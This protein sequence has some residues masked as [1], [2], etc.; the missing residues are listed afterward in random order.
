MVL[1]RPVENAAPAPGDEE[2]VAAVLRGEDRLEELMR[3]HNQRVFRAV[4]AIL[5]DDHEAEDV[6]QHAWVRAWE[7]LDQ[8]EHRARF[9]TWL[10]KIAVYEALARARKGRRSV[11]LPDE[12]P[13]VEASLPLHR[14]AD[15]EEVLSRRRAVEL[16]EAAVDE[17]PERLRS[18][19]VL[20][21]VEG[22]SA[23]ETAAA[24]D[25]SVTAVKVRLHRARRAL[26][27]RLAEYADLRPDELFGFGRERCDRLVARVG[28]DVHAPLT[29]RA[30]VVGGAPPA[31]EA[32]GRPAHDG[33]PEPKKTRGSRG[34]MAV[35]IS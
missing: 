9:S 34:E 4:R 10:V 23:R 31:R 21:E 24:L 33:A 35:T 28:A 27:T 17:L 22:M 5:G 14:T 32:D 20:R 18:V 13:D 26:R 6:A 2:L 8:F 25:V 16:L 12:L 11:P 7:H 1:D 29:R 30:G 15:L 3:R 19:Y